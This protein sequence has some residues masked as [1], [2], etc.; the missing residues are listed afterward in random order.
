MSFIF[1]VIPSISLYYNSLFLYWYKV[2]LKIPA[3]VHGTIMDASDD[4]Q[5]M[6]R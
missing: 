2:M 6:M 1:L 5:P 3:S 4:S